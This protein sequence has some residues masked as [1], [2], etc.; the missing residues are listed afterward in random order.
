MENPDHPKDGPSQDNNTP[1]TFG[2]PK[3]ERLKRRKLI[4]E[5]FEQGRSLTEFPVKLIYHPCDLAHKVSVQTA[6]TVP[7]RNFKKAVHRNRIKRLM[8]E[9]YRQN[10]PRILGN[11][12]RQYAF[13]FIYLGKELPGQHLISQSIT[14]LMERFSKKTQDE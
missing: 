3:H 11:S 9:V 2:F 4:E 14:R 7:K 10:K 1:P 13:L 12:Q 5:V 8:R 6:V